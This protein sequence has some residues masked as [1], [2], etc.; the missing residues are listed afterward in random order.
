MLRSPIADWD[1]DC[2]IYIA[3]FNAELSTTNVFWFLVQHRLKLND[4]AQ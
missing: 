3:L 2:H 4:N 1:Y